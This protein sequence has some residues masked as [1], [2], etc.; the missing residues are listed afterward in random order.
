MWCIF[1]QHPSI[2]LN[3]FQSA[4]RSII[5]DLNEK[6]NKT[7]TKSNQK[8]NLFT[9]SRF[10]C[11]KLNQ[12]EYVFHSFNKSMVHVSTISNSRC[13]TLNYIHSTRMQS[14]VMSSEGLIELIGRMNWLA[15][16]IYGGSGWY[17]N[18]KDFTF[19]QFYSLRSRTYF[20]PHFSF[21]FRFHSWFARQIKKLYF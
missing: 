4:M 17:Q 8:T 9:Y 12:S 15:T 16:M 11:F 18:E 7:L 20:S 10:G 6:L 3:N 13:H 19:F 2:D 5:L 21:D 14:N 1:F